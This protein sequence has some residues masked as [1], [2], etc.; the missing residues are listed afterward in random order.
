MANENKLR[1]RIMVDANILVAGIGWPRFPYAV[2]Q[3][4]VKG[5]FQ[6]VLSQVIVDE[7]R[8]HISRLFPERLIRFERFLVVSRYEAVPAPK[9]AE[10]DRH[11]DLVR[12]PKD[13]HVALAAMNANV[14]YL[15]TQDKD[16]TAQDETTETLRQ[17]LKILLPGTFLREYMGWSSEALEAIHNRNWSDLKTEE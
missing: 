13:I 14:D 2:L 17:K 4:A 9:Q 1:L 7:S 15:V 6:I 12:D 11:P 3:Q 10:L 16:L 8:R 5:D